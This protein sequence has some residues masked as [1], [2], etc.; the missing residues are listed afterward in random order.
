MTWAL[1]V[2]RQLRAAGWVIAFGAA[3]DLSPGP[4]TFALRGAWDYE[5]T[6]QVPAS[7]TIAGSMTWAGAGS[8]GTFEGAA[9]WLEQLPGGSVHSLAGALSGEL[10]QDSIVDF[11]VQLGTAARWHVG[12]LR[13]D[14]ISGSWADGAGS[15]AS[16][17]WVARRA[18]LP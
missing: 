8:A 17:T 7:T 13:G 16:G 1:R 9:S 14:S 2:R 11:T 15:T 6:Q 18:S 3:C 4:D 10:M 5:A 12:V